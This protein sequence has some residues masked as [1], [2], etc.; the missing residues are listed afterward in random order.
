MRHFLSPL[1]A[2]EDR[3]RGFG[4][5]YV[6]DPTEAN[7]LR[8]LNPLV[9]D[10]DPVLIEALDTHIRSL[11]PFAQAY[12]MMYH[13]QRS[14]Q[15]DQEP[16]PSIRMWFVR[17]PEDKIRQFGTATV[18]R[19]S[20]HTIYNEVAIVHTGD[21][22][23]DLKRELCV[24]NKDGGPRNIF[25]H[26]EIIDPLCYVLLFPFGDRG[27]AFLFK[28]RGRRPIPWRPYPS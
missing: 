26:R 6:M 24:Y 23:G 14:L 1:Q 25:H 22:L 10:C 8:F 5:F 11:N 16:V 9:R 3:N 13:L 27:Y 2:R 7:E 19:N 20:T 18:G 4:E 15:S 12:K 17:N 21:E 28:S